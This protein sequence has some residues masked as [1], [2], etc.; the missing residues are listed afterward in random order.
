MPTNDVA[1]FLIVS[2]IVAAQYLRGQ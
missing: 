1:L 2:I